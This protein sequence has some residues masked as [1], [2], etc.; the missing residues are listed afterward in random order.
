[1]FL[2]DGAAKV[3]GDGKCLPSTADCQTLQMKRGDTAFIDMPG[4]DGGSVRQFQLDLVKIRTSKT[5]DATAARRSYA[6]EARGGRSALRARVS[7]AGGI[8]FDPRTGV[9]ITAKND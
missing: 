6:A 2:V 9:L 8:R 7:R 5:T 1:M 3:Q 4:A